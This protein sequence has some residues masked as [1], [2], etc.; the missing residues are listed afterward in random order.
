LAANA[1]TPVAVIFL[2]GEL[3]DPD[4]VPGHWWLVKWISA[5]IFL[6]AVIPLVLGGKIYNSLKVIM[7]VK[8]VVIVF[9]LLFLAIFYSHLD[10]WG[11]IV[12]GF[13]KFGNVPVQRAEDLN[14]NGVLDPGEDW[15]QD[16]N[17]DVVEPRLPPTVDTD[18]DG[19]A[20]AWELDENKQPIKFVD[21]DKDGFRDGDNIENLF[22]ALFTRGELP[23]IDYTLV[24]L[25]AAL[26]AIAGNG[27][28]T[29]T[30]ISNFTRDQGWGMGHHVGAIPSIVGRQD[31]TLSHVGTVFQITSQSLDRWR[32]WYRHVFRDQFAV[33]VPACFIG[34]ALPAMLSVE[35]LRRGTEAGDWNA[36]AMTA[37]GVG[38]AVANPPDDVLAAMTGLSSVVSGAAWGNL[39]WGLTL[40]CGFLVLAPS[41]ATTIDG[42][43]RRWVDVVWLHSSSLLSSPH[44]LRHF[45]LRHAVVEQAH[46][47]DQNRHA[48]LQFR[49]RIQLL[50]Y[51]GREPRLV[52]ARTPA[53]LVGSLRVAAR[54]QLFCAPR[55]DRYV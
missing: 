46:D 36:A 17:L 50:A 10:T 20:D 42:L 21:V 16:G 43:I 25:I 31:I 28:L 14:G 33:W 9:F 5:A 52:A 39:F 19:K 32:G 18:D 15:D 48:W 11:D 55:H 53:Q 44:F 34:V 27:G 26:A 41:M 35:F 47:A 37:Q 13:F 4:N 8:L 2:G 45:W 30:P 38:D 12:G 1:A 40:F 22:V 51:P 23:D 3:P 49:P 24:A 54:R 29:N 7:S 6:L